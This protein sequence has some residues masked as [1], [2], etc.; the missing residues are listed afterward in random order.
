MKSFHKS[1]EL[2]SKYDGRLPLFFLEAEDYIPGLYDNGLLE[3]FNLDMSSNYDL[4]SGCI[5]FAKTAFGNLFV[6]DKC[7]EQIFYYEPQLN[8][9]SYIDVSKK[10]FFELFLVDTDIRKDVLQ[11]E[12]LEKILKTTELVLHKGESLILKPWQMLG[13]TD[14][15]ENYFVGD[16]AVYVDMVRNFGYG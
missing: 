3:L 13:G 8:R 14:T 15:P 9:F 7:S 11:E 4:G 2:S 12:Y 5:V 1:Y 16:C 6:F 10:D